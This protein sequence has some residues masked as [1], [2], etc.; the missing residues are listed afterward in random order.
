MSID[1]DNGYYVAICSDSLHMSNSKA[2]ANHV[3]NSF[4]SSKQSNSSSKA[5]AKLFARGRIYIGY[6]NYKLPPRADNKTTTR[7]PAETTKIRLT[8]VRAN[9]RFI[10]KKIKKKIKK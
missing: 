10:I 9:S 6:K 1:T 2:T 7:G 4:Y 3:Y 5:A 8:S